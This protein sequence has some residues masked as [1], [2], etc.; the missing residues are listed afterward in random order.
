MIVGG[1][2]AGQEMCL[3]V[4]NGN[5][6]AEGSEIVL[7]P[8]IDTVAAGDGRELWWF[9]SHDQIVNILGGKCMG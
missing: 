8:C 4:E 5:V 6:N 3:S 7:E 1:I 2:S 9:G